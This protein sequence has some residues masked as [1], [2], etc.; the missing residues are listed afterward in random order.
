MDQISKMKEKLDN[1][2]SACEGIHQSHCQ[3]LQENGVM[4]LIGLSN[5]EFL[6]IY[7]QTVQL[8]KQFGYSKDDVD[9]LFSHKSKDKFDTLHIKT[10][11]DFLKSIRNNPEIIIR[12]IDE[13][14]NIENLIES[15]LTNFHRAAQQL[16]KGRKDKAKL[17]ETLKIKDEYDVQD[18]LHAFLRLHFDDITP[19]DSSPSYAG[20][21]SRIDFILNDHK[22]AIE[23]K[24]TRKTLTD[25]RI[26]EE[27]LI[28]I[29]RYQT[30]KNVETLFCFIYDP[31]SLINN[32]KRLAN[33]LEEH[34]KK[35][36]V[37][38]IICPKL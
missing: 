8:V 28:D 22:I 10:F 14:T 35:I 20:G 1:L 27:L 31:D 7:K 15:I 24:M 11:I 32:P 16:L 12:H 19:E 37:K 30:H 33:D 18:L 13:S 21:A 29:G 25:K 38:V 5:G 3:Y 26:G 6:P 17:R 9:S 36:K 34:S 23:V 4:P 2:I